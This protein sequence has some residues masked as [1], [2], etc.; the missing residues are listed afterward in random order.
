MGEAVLWGSL[1]SSSLILGGLLALW[2]RISTR[3]LGLV[4]AFGAGVLI[5]AVALSS[6]KRASR[7][8]SGRPELA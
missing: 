8:P 3:V 2:L 6:S 1:A 7:S 5:S 4:M